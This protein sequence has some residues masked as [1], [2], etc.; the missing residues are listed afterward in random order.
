MLDRDPKKM[1]DGVLKRA[2]G[3]NVDSGKGGDNSPSSGDPSEAPEGNDEG[4]MMAASE[5]LE[6]FEK[7]DAGALMA[8]L[9]S[10]VDQCQSVGEAVDLGDVE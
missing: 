4:K 6:A 5:I 10:F 2:F 9:Q 3:G 1:A 7:K 8:A